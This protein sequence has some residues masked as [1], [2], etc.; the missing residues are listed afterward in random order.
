[1]G[2]STRA[3]GDVNAGAA[4]LDAEGPGSGPVR[5]IKTNQPVSGKFHTCDDQRANLKAVVLE[6]RSCR[7]I[8]DINCKYGCES[9]QSGKYPQHCDKNK[10]VLIAEALELM[11]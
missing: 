1:M 4:N 8:G 7:R 10:P 3:K 2:R 9:R 5:V 11:T 6:A